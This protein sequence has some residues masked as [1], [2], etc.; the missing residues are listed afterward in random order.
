MIIRASEYTV[1]AL[2]G[3]ATIK[4]HIVFRSGTTKRVVGLTVPITTTSKLKDLLIAQAFVTVGV[5]EENIYL[6]NITSLTGSNIYVGV[7]NDASTVDNLGDGSLIVETGSYATTP[8]RL[9]ILP[10][11]N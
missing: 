7:H 11:T 9:G 3:T 2:T 1:S 6:F 4:G 10:G 8:I 5:E